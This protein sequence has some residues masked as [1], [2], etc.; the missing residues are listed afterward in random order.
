MKKPKSPKPVPQLS[1][2][3]SPE[4]KHARELLIQ[5]KKILKMNTGDDLAAIRIITRLVTERKIQGTYETIGDSLINRFVDKR[6][7]Y[8]GDGGKM[9]N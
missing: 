6:F 2:E 4:Q 8:V 9:I 3:S 7:P 1:A 5:I